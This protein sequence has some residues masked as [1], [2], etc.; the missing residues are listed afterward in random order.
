[1]LA[2][3]V[4]LFHHRVFEVVAEA[5]GAV[6]V[7]VVVHP[8]IARRGLLADR[9]ERRVRVSSI[10]R[11]GVAVV[12]DAQGADAAVVVRHVL[13]QPVDGVPGVA[14]LDGALA[15]GELDVAGE[16][17][18]PL[19][20]EPAADVLDHQDVAV[21]LQRLERGRHDGR[22]LVRHAIG[23][24]ADEDR[25]GLGM[26][27]GAHDHRLQSHP[28]AHGDHHLLERAHR[29]RGGGGRGRRRRQG[30]GHGRGGAHQGEGGAQSFRSHGSPWPASW[31]P[32]LKSRHG[33]ER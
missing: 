20:L 2:V 25:Q 26:A 23:R 16:G 15:G 32:D 13:D 3:F 4:L 18:R 9:L 12:G 31:R 29:R 6:A 28:V 14:G 19:G 27:R 17:E 10:A 5:E 24:A 30:T 1:M 21:L 22:H 33:Y 7:V 8:L 11:G